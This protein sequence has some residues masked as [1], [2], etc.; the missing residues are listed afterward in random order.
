MAAAAL[1]EEEEN[2]VRMSLLLTG[3]SPRAA[4][5]LFD[6]EYAPQCLEASIKKEYNKLRDLKLK[7]RINQSQWNLLFPRYPDVPDSKTFD[8]TLMITLLRNL[9]PMIPPAGGY[10]QLP[11]TTETTPGADLARIKYYRNFLAH[12]DDG[13]IDITFFNTA[14]DDISG[15]ID[16]LGGRIMKN[17]CDHLKT[18]PLDQTNQEIMIEIKHSNDEIRELKGSL[19]SLKLSHIEMKRTHD[20]L[21]KDYDEGKKVH[22]LLKEDHE[23]VKKS[24]ALLQEKVENYQQD[25]VPWNVRAQIKKDLEKWKN[26]EKMFVNTRAALQVLNAIQKNSCVTITASSGV[27]KTAILQHVALQMGADGYDILIVTDPGDIAKYYNPNQKTLFVVDDLCGN[28]SLH[29]TDIKL[30]E[31]VIGRINEVL[32]D[33]QTKIIVACRLQVFQ[34]DKFDTLSIFKSCVCNLLSDNMCLLTTEKHSIAELYLTNKANQVTDYYDLYDCFPLLCQLY[35]ENPTHDIKHFFQNPFSVYEAQVD[36]LHKKGFF[37]KFCVLALCVMFNNKVDEDILTEEIDEN[38]KTVIA[39]TCEACKLDRGTSRLILKDELESLLNTLLRK[40]IITYLSRKTDTVMVDDEGKTDRTIEKHTN[41]LKTKSF[42][43]AIHDKIF[44]FLATY[45][46]K[47]I[48]ACLIKNADNRLIQERFLL[49]GKKDTDQF[50]TIVPSKYHQMYMQR[51]IDDWSKGK[52]QDVFNNSNM[53]IHQ[54]RERFLVYLNELDVFYQ[55]QLVH[56]DDARYNKALRMLYI[57]PYDSDV[58]CDNVMLYCCSIGDIPM[59]QWCCNHG[60]DVNRLGINGQSPITIACRYGHTE[61]IRM[62]LDKGADYNKCINHGWSPLMMACRYG[63]T[64]IV[65]ILLDI[66]ADYNKCDNRGESSL[67]IACKNG[68]KEVA[69]MLLNKEIDIKGDN[70]DETSLMV[71]CRYGH[72][73][74]VGVL[75]D[76]GADYHKCNEKGQSPIMVSCVYGDTEIVRMLLDKGADHNECD[77]CGLTPLMNACRY[78]NTEIVRMLLDKGADYN[79]CDNHNESSVMIACKY[80]NN[81]IVRMLLDEGADFNE[82]DESG[83]SPVMVACIKGDTEI[84]RMLLDKGADFNKCNKV[85]ES[86]VRFACR[87]GHKE[88]VSMLLDRGVDY[89]QCDK[90]GTSLLQTAFLKANLQIVEMLLAK[91][92]DCDN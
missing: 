56:T 16:R 43:T 85:G 46:G 31:P 92:A 34:D 49:E 3:I 55:K 90:H 15:A 1:S 81:K 9:T 71:A 18:K 59:I 77:N 91:G 57:Q 50:I 4:R 10:D 53:K 33:K 7:N 29:Q 68:Q 64:E 58:V 74:E 41:V 62:L 82:C 48:I 73:G 51:I 79:K 87:H 61:V 80:G 44:D 78:N 22:S 5:A 75:L 66:G 30:W 60:V 2:Y 42:Y 25:T 45:F 27:G 14:W 88:I 76:N 47:K 72:T 11:A 12:L 70:Y 20:S 65:K 8:I 13:K 32:K 84:V 83:Q 54:F 24:H 86:P 38:I 69:R 63:C 21:Q 19:E 52:L 89:K 28:F 40:Q 35:Y 39:N 26:K 67:M 6:G 37:G 17:E 36:Q 23:R